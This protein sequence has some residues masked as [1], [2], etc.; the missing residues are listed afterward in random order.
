MSARESHPEFQIL[1]AAGIVLACALHLAPAG[2]QPPADTAPPAANGIRDAHAG[3]NAAVVR[4]APAAVAAV[5]LPGSHMSASTAAEIERINEQMALLQAQL[6]QLE[7]RAKIASKQKEINGV[8]A[9]YSMPSAFGGKNGSPSVLSVA[10]LKGRLE[11]VLVFPGGVTQRVRA[12][13][14]MDDR[15]VAKVALTEV[16]LTDLKG[17]HVQRLAFGSS[18]ITRELVPP[19]APG[20]QPVPVFPLPAS[21]PGVP[22]R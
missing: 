16:V 3:A 21:M 5:P 19:A 13:D 14:V 22:A 1:R 6:N 9:P 20:L 2:A 7:L 18:P 8:A 11:A 12:G 15:R 17:G 4:S 10:G